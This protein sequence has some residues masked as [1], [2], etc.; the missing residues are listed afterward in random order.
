[1][2]KASHTDTTR[3]AKRNKTGPR[4]SYLLFRNVPKV[5]KS[6]ALNPTVED[7]GFLRNAEP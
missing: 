4:E 7:L 6:K 3:H 1:M 5:T 2:P